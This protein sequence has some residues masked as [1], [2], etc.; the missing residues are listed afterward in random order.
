MSEAVLTARTAAARLAKG[1]LRARELVEACLARIDEVEE[2]VQA[3]T[4]LDRDYALKQASA[5]DDARRAGRPLGPL[6]GLPVGIKDIIDTYDMPTENGTVLHA[7]RRPKA[8]AAVVSQLRQAGAIILGKT[9]TTELAVYGP[10]K[11]RNPHNPE[12]TPGGS[13]SGSAAAVAAGMVPLAVGTQ[14]NGSVIRPASYCGVYGY[15]PTHGLVSRRGVLAQSRPLDTVGF[16]ASCVEDLALIAQSAMHFDPADPDM[17]PSPIPDLLSLAESEPP[18]EPLFAFVK[19]PFWD[20]ASEAVQAGLGELAEALGEQCD[21]VALPESYGDALAYQRTIMFADLARSFAG[22]YQRGRA[23]LSDT[24]V[25]MIEEGQHCL[26]VDYNNAVGLRGAFSGGMDEIF[27][28]FDV[29]V[30]PAATGEAPAGLSATGDPVFA[31]LW[32]Y[33]G[34]P[35]VTL[36]LLVGENGLPIGVQLTAARGDDA[37]LLRTARWLARH[38]EG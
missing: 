36:P 35:S 7:G 23:Q 38:L 30:T 14:T 34:M 21:E 33:C 17:H 29:I 22:E 13:S 31:T 27:R 12:H 19:S 1:E 10:G 5:A 4:F 24:L 3:W 8:D 26:A 20:R 6:H 37:R 25:E 2:T 16:F 11:T 28:R 9:V 32:T 18:V 15:K